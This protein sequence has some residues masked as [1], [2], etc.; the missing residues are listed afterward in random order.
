MRPL[1]FLV[2]VYGS[3]LRSDYLIPRQ[4]FLTSKYQSL[5][6]LPPGLKEN[7]EKIQNTNS[8][9]KMVW[10]GN[11]DCLQYFR[12]KHR[13]DIEE[14]F[15]KLMN[16]GGRFASDLCRSTYLYYEGGFYLDLDVE[17]ELPLEQLV[18]ADTAFMSAWH[19]GD[20]TKREMFGLLNA[21]VGVE[22]KSKIFE[23]TLNAMVSIDIG[24]LNG[25]RRSHFELS[26]TQDELD[27]QD[28][29]NHTS[30]A[31]LDSDVAL[32]RRLRQNTNLNLRTTQQIDFGPLT[33]FEGLAEFMKT[34]SDPTEER[35]T[36]RVVCGKHIRLFREVYSARTENIR[37]LGTA[38]D[39]ELRGKLVQRASFW[40]KFAL[41][42]SN[43]EH[44]PRVIGWSRFAGCKT[45]RCEE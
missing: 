22:P 25:L 41:V 4:L 3:S 42:Y 16:F 30:G 5:S 27:S 19:F 10:F 2:A 33:L 7:V 1:Y 8:D 40:S 24:G 20:G 45:A 32:K 18:E 34:C 28:E 37:E 38:L 26:E 23:F 9:L 15:P 12:L 13:H 31:A 36:D 17:L 35:F 44:A 39:A 21:I 29:L 14:L 6:E 43:G 11:E